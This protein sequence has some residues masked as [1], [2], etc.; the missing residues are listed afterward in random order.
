[1]FN[2]VA[3]LLD[4]ILAGNND[5][6]KPKIK[7][8]TVNNKPKKPTTRKKKKKKTTT[9]ESPVQSIKK[10]KKHPK[11]ENNNAETTIEHS[12]GSFHGKL[13]MKMDTSPK[14][15]AAYT[16]SVKAFDHSEHNKSPT[17]GSDGADSAFKTDEN[18][19]KQNKTIESAAPEAL[20]AAGAEP[21]EV[22][23][24]TTDLA[25][26]KKENPETSI[27]DIIKK[28]P[29]NKNMHKALIVAGLCAGAVLFGTVAAISPG[30]AI[31]MGCSVLDHA[32][33]PEISGKVLDHF[34]DKSR[35]DKD[36]TEEHEQQKRESKQT[37]PSGDDEMSDE[38]IEHEN[39]RATEIDNKTFDAKDIASGMNEA[40]SAARND[41]N[42]AKA[43][44][45][46]AT[47]ALEKEK[48]KPDMSP[49]E[50][51]KD[52]ITQGWAKRAEEYSNKAHDQFLSPE[53]RDQH[54]RAARIAAGIAKAPQQQASMIDTY[55][56]ATEA[57]ENKTKQQNEPKEDD[58]V[59]EEEGEENPEYEN[60]VEHVTKAGKVNIGD[61]QKSL[62]MGYGDIQK[63]LQD[64]EEEGVVSKPDKQG[65]RKVLMT[66]DEAFGDDDDEEPENEPEPPK[67]TKK[68]KKIESSLNTADECLEILS[69]MDFEIFAL[70]NYRKPKVGYAAGGQDDL[71]SLGFSH[72]GPFD[73][74]CDVLDNIIDF[75]GKQIDYNNSRNPIIGLMDLSGGHIFTKSIKAPTYAALKLHP[76]SSRMLKAW[77][78][79]QGIKNVYPKGEFHITVCYSKDPIHY[80]PMIF[81]DGPE[82]VYPQRFDLLGREDDKKF[83][84]LKLGKGFAHKRFEYAREMGASHDF[85]EYLPHISISPPG[86]GHDVEFID[87]LNG[88]NNGNAVKLDFPLLVD[89]EYADEL[90]AKLEA[91]QKT[92]SFAVEAIDYQSIKNLTKRYHPQFSKMSIG[93]EIECVVPLQD[94]Q[95]DEPD[96]NSAEQ[97][98]RENFSF[99]H[100][101]FINDMN[102][103]G[104]IN[105]FNVIV[106]DQHKFDTEN[107]VTE[108]T[109]TVRSFVAKC[110]NFFQDFEQANP[111]ATIDQIKSYPYFTDFTAFMEENDKECQ[112]QLSDLLKASD[113][114][115]L[116]L[117]NI[118]YTT[119]IRIN[120]VGSTDVGYA[121]LSALRRILQDFKYRYSFIAKNQDPETKTEKPY[122]VMRYDDIDHPDYDD[123]VEY[124][125]DEFEEAFE[126]ERNSQFNARVE[127]YLEQERESYE[128]NRSTSFSFEDA[129]RKVFADLKSIGIDSSKDHVGGRYTK[130][131]IE[132][133]GSISDKNNIGYGVEIVSPKFTNYNEGLDW[134]NKVTKMM[135]QNDYETNTT[136]GFH[137]NIGGFKTVLPSGANI[138]EPGTLDLIKLAV[139]SGDKYLLS[140]FDRES[141][142]Y[143][144]SIT[145]RLQMAI[146]NAADS[147]SNK[148]IDQ[149]I[150]EANQSYTDLDDRY[151]T[152]NPEKFLS[153]GYIEFRVAGGEDYHKGLSTLTSTIYRFMQLCAV[154]SDYNAFRKDYLTQLG[155]LLPQVDKNPTFSVNMK[156]EQ[157]KNYLQSRGMN[158]DAMPLSR[159][160][161]LSYSTLTDSLH[162]SASVQNK[163]LKFIKSLRLFWY[164]LSVN[165]AKTVSLLNIDKTKILVDYR[166]NLADI[167][168]QFAEKIDQI[169]EES[170]FTQKQV[171][172]LFLGTPLPK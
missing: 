11:I 39:R 4:E 145:D 141:N 93:F 64:M 158:I 95:N 110:G 136:T 138:K 113:L 92:P 73:R 16:Q 166:H 17:D 43:V 41:P 14:A 7:K 69:N 148:F 151:V 27:E 8:T 19:E 38:Q 120:G 124:D 55:H 46:A 68:G 2:R 129:Q 122:I 152:I 146:N 24:G 164:Y 65:N 156:M 121:V 42:A 26:A 163:D 79:K 44:Q 20:K 103:D 130:T 76:A 71:D 56:S 18:G 157:V 170:G 165:N 153:K 117:N 160:T 171:F 125:K 96:Y 149:L 85:P 135:A 139:F 126:Q 143:A 89:Y 84:V 59:D 3:E 52:Q 77:C 53:E 34:L 109:P 154:A 50:G 21:H 48:N 99:D 111:N 58:N 161:R 63:H 142:S 36:E 97:Y 134:L 91:M 155:K 23:S 45:E 83:L 74:V 51:K 47:K 167:Y 90:Q 33:S 94:E 1:M 30:V 40:V 137:V 147:V 15:M 80:K 132:T 49:I 12:L 25:N 72:I 66:Y 168:H 5:P 118:R 140:K 101:D 67:P 127:D 35:N 31:A 32:L 62:G 133:D 98:V 37:N 115:N 10:N 54:K 88:M 86:H 70:L 169:A 60:A 159:L 131:V 9:D 81:T 28:N 104:F 57:A 82:Q 61:M 102:L 162:F 123:Y 128:N 13:S 29:E 116:A 105:D 6:K 114:I 108:M 75:N 119:Q 100:S 150:G 87:K 107:V 106:K 112:K 78:E 172:Y 22:A 144:V